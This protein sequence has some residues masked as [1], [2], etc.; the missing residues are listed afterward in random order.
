M[1]T[2]IIPPNLHYYHPREGVEALIEGRLKVRLKIITLQ[3]KC[4]FIAHYQIC[5]AI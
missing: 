3:A 2:G 1:E 5:M 4:L